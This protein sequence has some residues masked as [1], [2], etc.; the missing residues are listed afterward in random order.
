[1]AAFS[2]VLRGFAREAK[3]ADPTCDLSLTVALG[4][5]GLRI[6][7]TLGPAMSPREDDLEIGDVDPVEPLVGTLEQLAEEELAS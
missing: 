5:G 6:T 2:L 7:S 1:M 4:S 3:G